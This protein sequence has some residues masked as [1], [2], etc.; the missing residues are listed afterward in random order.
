[1]F[2]VFP[3]W[4]F[5]TRQCFRMCLLLCREEENVFS[6]LHT[7]IYTDKKLEKTF[8]D[9]ARDPEI[10]QHLAND[11]DGHE[12]Q[13]KDAVGRWPQRERHRQPLFKLD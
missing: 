4:D 7:T 10:K 8:N 5:Y 12:E 11:K 2:T 1:M 13:T 9:L 6:N 3:A